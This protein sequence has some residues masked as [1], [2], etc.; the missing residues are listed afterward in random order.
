M[1]ILQNKLLETGATKKHALYELA[2]ILEKLEIT[3][4]ETQLMFEHKTMSHR[5]FVII[6]EKV[7][8][9]LRKVNTQ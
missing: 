9:K 3:D 7:I 1:G 4:L 5:M 8:N 6:L 2:T